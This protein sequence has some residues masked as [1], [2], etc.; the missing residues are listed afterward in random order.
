MDTQKIIAANSNTDPA[1]WKST[2]GPSS[3]VGADYWL[4][5]QKESLEPYVCLDQS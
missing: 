4:V 3:R 2:D 5:N 1:D